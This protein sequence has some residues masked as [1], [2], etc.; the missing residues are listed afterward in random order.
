MQSLLTTSRSR[1][2]IALSPLSA[3]RLKA[4]TKALSKAQ[5]AYLKAQAFQGVAGEICVFYD[6]K[7]KPEHAWLGVESRN[8]IWS[9][10]SAAQKLP[11]DF[12]YH[13]ESGNEVAVDCF[14][15]ALGWQLAG[16][17]FD[18]YKESSQRFATLYVAEKEL[19]DEVQEMA[20]ATAL[21]RDLINE[22]PN[23]MHSVQLAEEVRKLAGE[24]GATFS[25]I[26]G[27]DLLKKNYPTIHM[28]GRASE[29]P[30]LLARL[31]WGNKK[32]P[33]IALVGK[34]VCF[35][36]GGLNI[37]P[38][39]SMR[40]MKKD[41]GGAAFVL[42]L[43]RL[44][45]AHQLPVR[46]E[47]FVP[48][49]ENAISNNAY[50]PQDVV[51]TRKG[52]TVEVSNTDAEGRLI[53]C[54][55]LAEADAMQPDLLVD[56]ATLTGA[57]RVAVGTEMPA[58]FTPDEQ[59]AS[60]LAVLAQQ[61]QDMMWRLPLWA[62]YKKLL[63]SKVADIDHAASTGYGGAITAALFLKEFVTTPQWLHLDMMAWNTSDRPGRPEGGEAQGLRTLFAYLK[64]R[65]G[66]R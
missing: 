8:D 36:S 60:E 1:S 39:S 22:P 49:V 26:V 38:E 35:D 41:M 23:V 13:I 54:D 15:A 17:V 33:L 3:D 29:S 64:Q 61:Q 7:G 2:S 5:Q 16:Y 12:S 28:V 43:A 9:W 19:V 14:N 56:A 66:Q 6:E 34:G 18:R 32:D 50:R 27:D 57:A 63:K 24:Y 30:P 37:K 47:L 42:G 25:Q 53:L 31:S 55:A 20:T 65:Y 44:I 48:A 45:M 62:E 59:I 10:A 46:L 11:A 51:K 40:L 21:V 58:F 4:A 52:I